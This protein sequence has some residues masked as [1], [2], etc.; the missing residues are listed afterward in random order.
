VKNQSWRIKMN[1][2]RSVAQLLSS[3]VVL[4]TIFAATSC[5]QVPP[6]QARSRIGVVDT[7]KIF[8]RYHKSQDRWQKISA[9][10]EDIMELVADL[11]AQHTAAT[12]EQAKHPTGSPE[13][14]EQQRILDELLTK[15]PGLETQ[16]QQI[17]QIKAAVIAELNAEI[18]REVE[19]VGSDHN[20]D[21]VLEKRLVLKGLSARPISWSLVHYVKPALDLTSRVIEVLNDKYRRL[22]GKSGAAVPVPEPEPEPEPEPVPEPVPEPEPEPVDSN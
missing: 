16:R 12:T 9:Q 17:I 2:S 18:L 1:G 8:Q 21:L 6:Q 3:C 19:R 4:L 10:A 22:T 11:K 20:L 5:A 13:F 7:D 14:I 15:A